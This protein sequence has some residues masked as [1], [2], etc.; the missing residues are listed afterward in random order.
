MSKQ[1]GLRLTGPKADERATN[2][3]S[4]TLGYTRTAQQRHFEVYRSTTDKAA[5]QQKETMAAYRRRRMD[6]Y[7]TSG[8]MVDI[9]SHTGGRMIDWT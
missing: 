8:G 6:M 4:C 3:S 2:A 5:Q 9:S 7:I 1:N